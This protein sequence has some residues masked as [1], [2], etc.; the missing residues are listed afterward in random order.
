MAFIN[1]R[2]TDLQREDFAKRNIKNPLLKD[3]LLIPYFWTADYERNTFLVNVGSSHDL[4]EEELFIFIRN[5]DVFLFKL[6]MQ[7][8]DGK[9]KKWNFLNFKPISDNIETDEDLLMN[10]FKEALTEYKYNGLP[11]NY[12]QQFDME[13]DFDFYEDK[14]G[15]KKNMCL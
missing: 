9:T 10:L 8:V 5:Q 15:R 11:E 6:E 1:E 7:N 14:I 4:P 2:L 13:I 3:Q 12:R